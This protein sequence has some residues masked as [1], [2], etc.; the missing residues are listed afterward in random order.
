LPGA[1][2]PGAAWLGNAPF[3]REFSA[4]AQVPMTSIL[5]TINNNCGDIKYVNPVS[6]Q[7]ITK[8]PNY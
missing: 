4:P 5:T 2:L 6:Y 3:G 7:L 8:S 1:S